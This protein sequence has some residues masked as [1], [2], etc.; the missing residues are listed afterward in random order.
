LK[1]EDDCALYSIVTHVE[2][3]Y[4]LT[5]VEAGQGLHGLAHGLDGIHNTKLTKSEVEAVQTSAISPDFPQQPFPTVYNLAHED[6]EGKDYGRHG[7]IKPENIL[8]FKQDKSHPKFGILKLSDFD[9]P[10]FTKHG[11]QP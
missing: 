3:R 4:V 8:W 5:Y 1:A 9:S 7:D 10:P 11:Q 6:D 2:S